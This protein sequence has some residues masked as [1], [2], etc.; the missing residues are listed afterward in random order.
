MFPQDLRTQAERLLEAYKDAGWTLATAE[1]CTG[2]LIAG[3]LTEVP[4]SSA[5]V[6]RGFVTYTNKAKRE[7]LGVGEATLA[8]HG[9]VSA[10]VARQMAEGALTRAPVQAAVAVTGVAGPSGGT[11]DKPVGR[12]EFALA[13]D[14]LATQTVRHDLSGDRGQIRLASV[15]VALDLLQRALTHAHNR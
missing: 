8:E 7:M 15:S 3:L 1:S 10:A 11:P 4:G 9:A 6:E 12:V 2:G 5:V 13:A 14:G